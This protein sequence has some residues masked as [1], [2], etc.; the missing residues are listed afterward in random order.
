MNLNRHPSILGI[1]I[2]GTNI[3]FGIFEH[4]P[5]FKL[6]HQNQFELKSKKPEKVCDFI[7]ENYNE[8]RQK[9]KVHAIGIGIAGMIS[10]AD[11]IVINAPNLQWNNFPFKDTLSKKIKVPLTIMNDLNAI[12]WGEFN[13]GR[14]KNVDSMVCIFIGTG[15]GSGL[16]INK[17]LVIG[18]RG[19]AGEMGHIKVN[20]N[21][22]Y[23]VCGCG[24][25]GCLET[26][27]GGKHLTTRLQNLVQN[28]QLSLSFLGINNL[29]NLHPGI[30]D[31][32][33]AQ[34]NKYLDQ[35]W[36]NNGKIFGQTLANCSTLL[37]PHQIII[38]GTVWE[39]TPNFRNL[40]L[41][42]YE[43]H[44]NETTRAEIVF[45]L[46]KNEAGLYGAASRAAQFL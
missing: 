18:A 21:D 39:G 29:E 4:K 12:T 7:H 31:R 15:V 16:V 35:L 10:K 3:R 13:Y 27:I 46:L 17:K 33:F 36:Y 19:F 42:S 32:V 5:K 40:T 30:A 1:D 2:G 24:K 37:N 44:L 9:Y 8:I 26:Y 45:P 14:G 28:K 41:Q 11:M 6:V 20:E 34:G 38:G 23:I 22:N 43:K 25:T